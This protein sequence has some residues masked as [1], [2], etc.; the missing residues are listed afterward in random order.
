M[1]NKQLNEN[2]RNDVKYKYG[3]KEETPDRSQE[4]KRRSDEKQ[5]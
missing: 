4:K 2:G 1:E 3:R 5:L